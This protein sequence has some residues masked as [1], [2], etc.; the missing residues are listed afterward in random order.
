MKSDFVPHIICA[1]RCPKALR[2]FQVYPYFQIPRQ[3]S[4]Q[5]KMPVSFLGFCLLPLS[6]TYLNWGEFVE[7]AIEANAER[8]GSW[9][10]EPLWW[11]RELFV[12]V[13]EG[14]D[15]GSMD[16]RDC[17]PSSSEVAVLNGSRSRACSLG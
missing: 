6:Q 4:N 11:R 9:G 5:K 3:S 12:E 16:G 15:I 17:L 7:E 13:E 10:R 14:R 8:P 1:G 2:A